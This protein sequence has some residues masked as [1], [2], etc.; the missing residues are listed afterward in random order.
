MMS[1]L[2]M[3]VVLCSAWQASAQEVVS[4]APQRALQKNA[5]AVDLGFET[6]GAVEQVKVSLQGQGPLGS[7]VNLTDLVVA[8]DLTG[9]IPFHA[10]FPLSAPLPDGAVLTVTVKPVAADGTT[11]TAVS[12]V[13]SMS[14]LVRFKGATQV[15]AGARLGLSIPFSGSLSMAEVTLVGTS[16]SALRAVQGNVNAVKGNAYVNAT[17]VKAVPRLGESQVSFV[18][19]TYGALPVDAVLIAD[20]TLEDAFGRRVHQSL[21]ENVGTQIDTLNGLAA[22]PSSVVLSAGFA[23]RA[24]LLVLA[25]YALAGEIPL[26]GQTPGL[27]FTSSNESVVA[28][29][30][31]GVLVARHNGTATVSAN[32][33]GQSVAVPVT[34]DSNATI[35]SLALLPVVAEIPSIGGQLRM[36]AAATLSTGLTVDVSAAETGTIFTSDNVA[37]AFAGPDG[38]VTGNREG[39]AVIRVRNGRFTAERTVVVRDAF[40]T[41]SLLGPTAVRADTEFDVRANASDDVGVA[42]VEFTLNSVPVATDTVPPF[43]FKFRA[44]PNVGTQMIIG[45]TAYDSAGQKTNAQVLKVGIVGSAGLSSRTPI[46]EIPSV[47]SILPTG[48]P[49]VVRMLSRPWKLGTALS[50]DYEVVHVTV[51]DAPLATISLPRTELRLN[52]DTGKIVL[53]PI[54]E[55]TWTPPLGREGTSAVLRIDAIDSNGRSTQVVTTIV[56]LAADAPPFVAMNS[57][58]LGANVTA[59][60]GAPLNFSGTVGDDALSLGLDI[61][62]RLDGATVASTRVFGGN[63]TTSSGSVPFNLTWLRRPS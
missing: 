35:A 47:G 3:G 49:Q 58:A 2:L 42:K 20:I 60:A 23:S 10:L 12:K 53:V 40:P 36:Q 30:S 15:T 59:T 7:F 27:T 45:A 62:L 39:S 37:V 44:S 38:N 11:G 33:L 8:K 55:T 50:S 41:V 43:A 16:S 26:D 17:R 32:F 57:P 52:P 28:V 4:I 22:V 56:G 19:E 13:F 25:R 34:V 18:F 29:T 1:R 51:D 48:I 21:L 14:E 61:E 6:T 24:S 46:L 5:T 63:Y 54:W 31:A 9:T